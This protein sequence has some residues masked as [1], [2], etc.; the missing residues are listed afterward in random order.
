MLLYNKNF[1]RQENEEEEKID[2]CI[3]IFNNFAHHST[4]LNIL[5]NVPSR[6]SASTFLPPYESMIYSLLK[7]RG[8]GKR[9]SR[10][11][12]TSSDEEDDEA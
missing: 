4:S 2:M 8:G 6:T 3:L 7:T 1:L 10:K 5:P 11:R 9:K 12:T